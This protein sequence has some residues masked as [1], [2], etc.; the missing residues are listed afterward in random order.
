MD[1]KNSFISRSLPTS[2]ISPKTFDLVF[3]ELPIERELV[4][5]W[6]IKSDLLKVKAVSIAF[7]C[8]NRGF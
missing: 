8:R 1:L 6:D 7:P 4:N 3:N 5:I 2:D